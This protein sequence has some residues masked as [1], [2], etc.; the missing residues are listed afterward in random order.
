MVDGLRPGTS[1]TFQLKA[2]GAEFV[3]ASAEGIAETQSMWKL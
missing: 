1:Y 3:S 2:V